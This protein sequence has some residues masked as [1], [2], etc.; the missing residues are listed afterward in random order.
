MDSEI[1]SLNRKLQLAE[2][3]LARADGVWELNVLC[4]FFFVWSNFEFFQVVCCSLLV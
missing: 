1:M 4:Q 2:D 3:E